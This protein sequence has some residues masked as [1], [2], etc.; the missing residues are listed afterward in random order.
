MGILY[1]V[2]TPIGNLE[3]LSPRALRILRDV[4][5][6]AAEDTR[7]TAKLLTHFDIHTPSTSYYEHNKLSKLDSILDQL[8]RG[9]VALVS[10][11]GFPGISD[12]GY[13]LIRAAIAHGVAVSPI[14]GA[15]ALLV[16]LVASGLPTDSFVYLGFLPRKSSDRSRLLEENKG[17][18]RTLICFETPHRLIESLEDMQKVFGDRQIAVCREM[19]KLYEEIFRGL[20]SAAITH[21]NKG[22]VRGEITLVIAG[23]SPE[24]QET[25]SEDRVR[26]ALQ[27]LINDGTER[28]EAAKDVAAQSGWERRAVYKIATEL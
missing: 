11:G 24:A 17:D 1:I 9:D 8:T 13:E 25:W 18:A 14:P 27:Q 10:D 15:S 20:I 12:P 4:S 28:K 23:R 21:F 16:A 5:L 2:A 6:I 19:T 7:H 22:G 3:D 26:S